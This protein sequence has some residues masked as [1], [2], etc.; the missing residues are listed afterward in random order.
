MQGY[1]PAGEGGV[2]AQSREYYAETEEW[3]ASAGA[4]GL[5]HAELEARMGCGTGSWYGGCSR[6]T[7]TC[8]QHGSHGG[9]T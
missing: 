4:A 3:L 2:F 9:T 7:W 6:G 1:A 5:Q 8:C